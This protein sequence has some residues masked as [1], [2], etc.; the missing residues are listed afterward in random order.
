MIMLRPL[1]TPSG[2]PC[3]IPDMGPYKPVDG[4]LSSCVFLL[5]NV[6]I[7]YQQWIFM[8]HCKY[9]FRDMRLSKH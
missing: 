9:L 2:I 7:P 3:W 6:L 4:R 5:N 8:I 1:F